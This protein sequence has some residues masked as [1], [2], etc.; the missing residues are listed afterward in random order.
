MTRHKWSKTDVDVPT[1]CV[2]CGG[3]LANLRT[4]LQDCPG[5]KPNYKDRIVSCLFWAGVI[6]V[7]LAALLSTGCAGQDG[8]S[9]GMIA[10]PTPL[11]EP[12]PEP[13]AVCR[14]VE[15]PPVCEP[16]VIPGVGVQLVCKPGRVETVCTSHTID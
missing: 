9:G 8:N 4:S 3:T 14:Q 7:L 12:T 15:I 5:P 6:M 16:T 10:S 1:V 2:Y 13:V 11:P